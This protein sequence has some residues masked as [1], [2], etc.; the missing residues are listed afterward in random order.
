[1]E[2]IKIGRIIR[3]AIRDVAV[4]S[5]YRFCLLLADRSS[6]QNEGLTGRFSIMAA[7]WRFGCQSKPL[8]PLNRLLNRPLWTGNLGCCRLRLAR[9]TGSHAWSHRRGVH[10]GQV[11]NLSGLKRILHISEEVSEAVSANRP[12]VA[13]E[14]TIYTHGALGN[15]LDLEEIVRRHGAV[16]AVCGILGGVPTVG[17][18]PSEVELMVREGAS[19]VSRRD[20]AYVVGMVSRKH[21]FRFRFFFISLLF[22]LAACMCVLLFVFHVKRDFSN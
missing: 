2:G 13:L 6:H 12:V 9:H 11:A 21:R 10:S 19:K 14:S 7:A 1:M 5:I 4:V 15:D 16:P 20:L 17:L 18:L 3:R 8:A 22:L